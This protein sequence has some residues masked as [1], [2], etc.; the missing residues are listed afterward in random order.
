MAPPAECCSRAWPAKKWIS[1]WADDDTEMHSRWSVFRVFL[2][3]LRQNLIAVIFFR[4]PPPKKSVD[5]TKARVLAFLLFLLQVARDNFFESRIWKSIS[6]SYPFAGLIKIWATGDKKSLAFF[7]FGDRGL[8][9]ERKLLWRF[10]RN[11]D[12][13]RYNYKYRAMLLV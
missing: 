12:P 4:A 9:F 8:W 3:Q 6:R 13:C 5:R 1:L 11:L 7:G 10:S 2:F